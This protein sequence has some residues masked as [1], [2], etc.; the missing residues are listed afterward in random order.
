MQEN[1]SLDLSLSELDAQI[2]KRFYVN[3]GTPTWSTTVTSPVG[4]PAYDV[5]FVLKMLY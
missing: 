5:R 1:K 2:D 3:S 4:S